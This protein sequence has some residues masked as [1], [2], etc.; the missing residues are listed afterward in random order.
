MRKPLLLAACVF[1]GQIAHAQTDLLVQRGDN[2][3]TGANLAET[4]L[5]LANVNS[6]SF[7][8]VFTLPVDGYVYGQPL[9]KSSLTIPGQ[10]THNVVFVATEHDSVYAFDADSGAPLWQ[11]SFIN[12]A[13]G[14][15][16]QP[17]ADTGTTD[18][19]PEV[20]ITSTPV[21]DAT[22]GTLYVVAKTKE[23]GSAV[24][25][26]HAL[27]IASGAEK[28]PAVVIQAS[29][30]K[31]GGGT[32]P[33]NANWQQ[34]RP[35]LVLANGVVYVAFGSSGDN[36]IWQGWLLGYNASTLAQV[37][38]FC[39]EPDGSAGGGI[40]ASGEAPPLDASGNLYLTTG[41]GSFDAARLFGDAYVK[42]S[43]SANLAVVDY[44][45]PFNQA[46]MNPADLDVASAGATLLPDSAGTA[47]HPHL[48]V[49]AGKDGTIYLLDRDNMGHFNGSYSNPDSQI[50]EEIPNAIGILPITTTAVPLPYVE[51]NYSNAAFWANHLYW[52]GINDVC[53]MFN[54]S[55]GLLTTSAS[56]SASSYPFGGAEPVITASSP[57]AATAI[58]WAVERDTTNNITTLHAYDATTL[59]TEL[60]NSNQAAG[61]RDQGGA[62]VKFVVPT[63]LNGK[64]F[65][66]AQGEVDVY[67]L[68]ASNPPALPMPTFS[69]APGS[70]PGAQSV[71]ISD[72]NTAA[73]IYYTLDGSNP[74]TSATL[75]NGPIA[76]GS[77]TTFN[78][79]AVL[80]GFRVSPIASATY[81]I[82]AAPT[83]AFVQ[84][85]YATPQAPQTAVSVGFAALQLSGDLN[86]VVVGWNDSTRTVSSVTD[87]AGNAYSLA[88][89]PT[90]QSGTATQA[91][92]YARNIS[93][94]AA[95]ANTVTVS[96]NG[97]A[98]Y[99]D[100]RI[101][102]YSGLDA[103]NPLDVTAAA[104]G[105]GT[106]S[107]SGAATTS[108]ANDLI[109]GA[110]LVQSITT[111][112]G[113]GFTNRVI[114]APD[115][116]IAEDRVVTTT[117]SYTASAATTSGQWIMQ[118]AAFRRAGGTQT[119][120]PTAPG[121]LAVTA[122]SS[123]QIN[124]S[125]SASTE[126]GGT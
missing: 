76:L 90:V 118:M 41:N 122:V 102:E 5:T 107:S 45:A 55:N 32:L 18:I 13:A 30:A 83:I 60:Y 22:S 52:C 77:T 54:L 53:K 27:A 61:N 89:G 6:T 126:T 93:G 94:A 59:G 105:S 49:G 31:P 2:F 63:V 97:A 109:I 72:S 58:M 78:A 85:G 17:S 99:P 23:S 3:R 67:G 95:G 33:F 100:I 103:T 82:G 66:G 62:P 50:I 87:T 121:N 48:M 26:I 104:M 70:Y 124:L 28:L 123:A 80:S 24:F 108:S 110:N 79:I 81:T 1:A 35:G 75:Y 25:R 56:S 15:T 117:G 8:K 44:F 10:G 4:T 74:T 65:V 119:A 86:V 112:P 84:S 115:G 16:T 12:P 64:A 120:A 39:S 71:S 69:P 111:G 11:H 40:W 101:L 37:G 29:V 125:W 21:I 92:Y 7:G 36:F 19:T 114:T 43:T 106:S 88:A 38:V 42:L 73:Q 47:A 113:A 14:I 57:S 91:I 51:N 116:D 96:F 9:Y 20:G 46:A 98:A 34:Q 68:L